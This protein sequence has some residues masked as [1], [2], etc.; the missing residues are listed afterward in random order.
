VPLPPPPPSTH[1][2]PTMPPLAPGTAP[3]ALEKSLAQ[4]QR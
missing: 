3:F 2:T 4:H 1:A